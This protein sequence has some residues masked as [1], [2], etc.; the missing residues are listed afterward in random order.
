[1]AI[2]SKLHEAFSAPNF[3][4]RAQTPLVQFIQQV[5]VKY[6]TTADPWSLTFQWICSKKIFETSKSV[7]DFILLGLA[8]I[9][10]AE[11]IDI[12][13]VFPD[14]LAMSDEERTTSVSLVYSTILGGNVELD[15][16]NVMP[17]LTWLF[18]NYEEMLAHD[19]IKRALLKKC[20]EELQFLQKKGRESQKA[21]L[22]FDNH[23]DQS[24][25]RTFDAV[26]KKPAEKLA[27]LHLKR[28][29]SDSNSSEQTHNE[30][31]RSNPQPKRVKLQIPNA[32]NNN[33]HASVANSNT[34]SHSFIFHFPNPE[35]LVNPE[36][37]EQEKGPIAVSTIN[38]AQGVP[39]S[40]W[41]SLTQIDRQSNYFS[42]Q[43]TFNN[44]N[45]IYAQQLDDELDAIQ[46]TL[47][48]PSASSLPSY[49]SSNTD[50]Q[51]GNMDRNN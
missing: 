37:N 30:E 35:S 47:S 49:H 7:C 40:R 39:F 50:T 42:N 24:T 5:R 45:L 48:L 33:Y 10:K 21:G 18:L 51:Q 4:H 1:M 34:S 27:S 20:P 23:K 28:K 25:S 44:N 14:G 9:F 43:H 38:S 31:H 46:D 26:D 41:L 2:D 15:K 22:K 3:S 36:N 6:D 32:S 12:N 8:R 29:E 13:D 17:S 16:D 11:G 19:G